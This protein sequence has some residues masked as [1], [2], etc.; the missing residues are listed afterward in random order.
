MRIITKDKEFFKYDLKLIDAAIC[1]LLV[2]N[3]IHFIVAGGCFTSQFS[4]KKINDI[5]VFFKNEE[6]LQNALD[7]LRNNSE[8]KLAFNNDWVANIFKGKEKIQ[9]IKK[10]FYE[11][12]RQVFNAFDFTCVKFAYDGLNCFYH[13]RFFID[14]AARKLVI[15]NNLPKPLSTLQR[16]YKY[17]SRGFGICPFGMAEIAKKIQELKI[18]WENPNENDLQFYSDG[19]MKFRGLD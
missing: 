11:N 3:K 4:Q 10:Y 7:I 16:S 5:D 12:T 14:L 8:Y 9:F 15:D 1:D 6:N 18:D 13:E 19:T 17:V 2:K